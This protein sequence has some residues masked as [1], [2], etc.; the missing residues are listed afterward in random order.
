MQTGEMLEKYGRYYEI[1]QRLGTFPLRETPTIEELN[2]SKAMIQSGYR[3]MKEAGFTGNLLDFFCWISTLYM[4]HLGMT[5]TPKSWGAYR[6]LHFIQE[7]VNTFQADMLNLLRLFNK[8][9]QHFLTAMTEA[10]REEIEES[11]LIRE[12]EIGNKDV[13]ILS[14][15]TEVHLRENTHEILSRIWFQKAFTELNQ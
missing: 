11:E 4:V 15:S 8:D 14:K 7:K 9:P 2:I 5:S 1:L 6:I 13:D 3:D 10:L 12:K